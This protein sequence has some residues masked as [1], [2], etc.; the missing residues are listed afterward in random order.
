MERTAQTSGSPR[1]A[2]LRQVNMFLEEISRCFDGT[3]IGLYI[4]NTEARLRLNGVLIDGGLAGTLEAAD[5][6][7]LDMISP[8]IGVLL[9]RVCAESHTFQSKKVYEIFG[10][11]E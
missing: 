1:T 5:I 10:H 9:V 11:N 8:F 4:R 7:N 3:Q 2:I 6:K